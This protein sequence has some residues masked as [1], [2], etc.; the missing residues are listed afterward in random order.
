MTLPTKRTLVKSDPGGLVTLVYGA[1]KIGKSTL[2]SQAPS[3]LFLATEAGLNHLEVFQTP[4]SDWQN[5]LEI[6]A[7]V[8]AGKHSFKTLVIDIIDNAYAMCL[9]DVL[10]RHN[11]RHESDLPF[12]KGFTMV[13]REF[14]RVI[15]NIALLGLGLI[16]V[17]HA[18][19]KEIEDETGKKRSMIVPTLPS[20]ARKIVM[21]ISDLILYA[22]L[23]ETKDEAG[24]PTG[25]RRVLRTK[26]SLRYEAGDRTG[27]LPETI[28]M[29]YAAIV[30][31][32]ED[33]K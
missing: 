18:T 16:M 2:C 12:G 13:N 25:L 15:N 32:L 17:S 22:E 3:A 9:A 33:K 31:H 4:V 24:K 1:P 28:D 5:L 7:E 20:G 6:C 23:E 21:G 11:L 14:S 27:K 30:A 10:K 29:S 8:K 19:E 26:P